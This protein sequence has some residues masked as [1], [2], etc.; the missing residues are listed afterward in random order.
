MAIWQ[1]NMELVP[2]ARLAADPALI[3]KSSTPDDEGAN[4]SDTVQVDVDVGS[5]NLPGGSSAADLWMALLL[6][7]VA[8][9]RRA[10]NLRKMSIAKKTS[11]PFRQRTYQVA[12][13][14]H[15]GDEV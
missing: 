7:L 2:V 15:S 10:R 9:Q 13:T 14:T 4:T 6:L 12:L 11:R 5:L 8:R 3:E 1:F